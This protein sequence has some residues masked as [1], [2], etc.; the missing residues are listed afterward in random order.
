MTF[1]EVV[2]DLDEKIQVSSIPIRPLSGNWEFKDNLMILNEAC[3]MTG[4]F[5]SIFHHFF[6]FS[7]FPNVF[8]KNSIA[9]PIVSEENEKHTSTD[10]ENDG[11][12]KIFICMMKNDSKNISVEGRSNENA[13]EARQNAAVQFLHALFPQCTSF[14]DIKNEVRKLRKINQIQ[15]MNQRRQSWGG[16]AHSDQVR[17]VQNFQ[18]YQG[19]PAWNPYSNIYNPI[20]PFHPQMPPTAPFFFYGPPILPPPAPISPDPRMMMQPP[21]YNPHLP[22]F[23]Q[24]PLEPQLDAQEEENQNGEEDGTYEQDSSSGLESDDSQPK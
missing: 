15:K 5:I 13:K 2:K 22:M 14:D 21:F 12:A 20:L 23:S 10:T 17:M 8:S 19:Y 16:F 11:N 3:Q 6:F 4:F 24:R 7:H 1:Q 18:K 9:F